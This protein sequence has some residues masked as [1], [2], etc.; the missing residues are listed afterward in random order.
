MLKEFL[1]ENNK[2]IDEQTLVCL[3]R[4]ILE[5]QNSKPITQDTISQLASFFNNSTNNQEYNIKKV[6]HISHEIKNQLSIC[7]LYTE[8]IKKYCEK[9][10]IIDSTLLKSTECIKNAVKMAGNSLLE[11]KSSDTLDF[12]KYSLSDVLSEAITLSKVYTLNKNI[13][14]TTDINSSANVLI[15]KNKLLGVVINLI[16]NACEAFD[17][18]I[19]NKNIN[20]S[21]SEQDDF[22]KIIISNNA[23]PIENPEEIFKEGFTT[24]STGSGLGLYICKTNIEELF[25]KFCLLKS[26]NISTDFEITLTRC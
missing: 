20:I 5:H 17:D 8:I 26:D 11:L 12:K 6:R 15:D 1:K 10:N 19:E 4:V 22:I 25:G 9:N 13:N 24:K 16:K 23:K 2:L 3:F 18:E 14:I 7:D 21:V